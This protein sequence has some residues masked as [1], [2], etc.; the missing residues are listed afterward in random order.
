MVVLRGRE[1]LVVVSHG[2][3]DVRRQVVHGRR[4]V[5]GRARAV[6]VA[7]VGVGRGDGHGQAGAQRAQGAHRAGVH[8]AVRVRRVRDA[9]RE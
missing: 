8:R 7:A 5:V 2:D 1:G 6:A 3:L 4:G 9:G